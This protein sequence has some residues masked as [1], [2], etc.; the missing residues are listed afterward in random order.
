VTAPEV[1]GVANE[2]QILSF[3]F[4]TDIAILFDEV[5]LEGVDTQLS[6]LHTL[7]LETA[8]P[9]A[10]ETAEPHFAQRTTRA[11]KTPR[12]NATPAETMLAFQYAEFITHFIYLRKL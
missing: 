11:L 2:H 8:V 10:V 5:L 4:E 7:H 1:A 9:V 12:L 6:W 3:V